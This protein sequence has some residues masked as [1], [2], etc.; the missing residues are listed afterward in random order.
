M[1]GSQGRDGNLAA[2]TGAEPRKNAAYTVV[3]ACFCTQPRTTCP[4]TSLTNE[5]NAGDIF[6]AEIPSQITLDCEEHRATNPAAMTPL[7][8]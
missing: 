2:G 4:H 8:A 5:E 6:S 1:K 3:S 7:T